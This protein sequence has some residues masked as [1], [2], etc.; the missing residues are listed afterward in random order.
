MI[1]LGIY[2]RYSALGASSRLRY[3]RYAEFLKQR[4][5]DVHVHPLLPDR[6]IEKLYSGRPVR[7]TAATALLKRLFA[8]TLAE[9]NLWIE[10]ELLP[11]LS[12]E[13]EKFFLKKRRYV[14]NFDDAVYLKY[15]GNPRLEGKFERLAAAASGIMAANDAVLEHFSHFNSNLV[16]IPTA[17]DTDALVPS[18]QKFERFTVVWIGTPV[19]CKAHLEPF[20][21]TLDAIRR[22]VE[23]D[24][25]TIGGDPKSIEKFSWAKN[26]PWSEE[27]ERKILPRCHVGI[28][29][30]PRDDEFAAGKSAYKLLQY[31]AAGIPIVASP[32]GEN[33]VVVRPGENGFA[34]STPDEWRTALSSLASDAGMRKKLAANARRDSENYSVSRIAPAIADFLEKSFD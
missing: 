4:G 31:L 6:Y 15:R 32:V 11:F 34:A 22:E 13:T 10:Y 26:L 28:M 19:T 27:T 24:L 9:K 17:V 25:V 16:K 14:L 12:W 23:F 18:E 5:F 29:P 20:L 30:L 33:K 3:L 2:T 1:E 8:L 7:F 21:P